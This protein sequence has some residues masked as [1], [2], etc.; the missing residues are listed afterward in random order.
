MAAHL[1]SAMLLG[2]QPQDV[3][4]TARQP[5]KTLKLKL[6]NAESLHGKPHAR[7][8]GGKPNKL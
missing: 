2:Q 4:Q 6:N 5:A 1:N 3:L 7:H 8:P